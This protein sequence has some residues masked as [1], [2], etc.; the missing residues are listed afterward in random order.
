MASTRL[1]T[2]VVE[3]E[4]PARNYLVE[5]LEASGLAEVVGA[6][7]TLEQARQALTGDTSGLG[8]DVV[9]VDVALEGGSGGES[10]LSLVRSF[11]GT[12]TTM[13]VLATAY[14]QHAI[15]AFELGVADYLLKPFNEERVVQC[16]RRLVDRRSRE[17]RSGIPPSGGPS[18]IVA[19]RKRSLVFLAPSEIW[20]FEAA[21]RLTFVHTTHG[22]FDIDL[23]LAAVETSFGRAFVRVHRNWLVNADHIKELERDGPETRLFV[24]AGVAD[25]GKGIRVPVARERAAAVREMLLENATGLRRP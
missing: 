9:F 19:R 8:V 4:W 18:R 17:H 7:G 14:E 12:G 21:D 2:L 16:L 23:S 11:A 25:A 22:T 24:G 13:F 6:V 5:L 3:D 1:T 20:A 15:E 10:G